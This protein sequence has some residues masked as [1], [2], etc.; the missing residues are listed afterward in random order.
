M[1]ERRDCMDTESMR[2]ATRE[3]VRKKFGRKRLLQSKVV[4]HYPANLEREYVRIANT[5]MELFKKTLAEHLPNI[6]VLLEQG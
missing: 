3:A 4:P 2:Q 1:P 6:R 5:Y